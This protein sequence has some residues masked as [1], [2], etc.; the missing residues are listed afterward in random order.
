MKPAAFDYHAPESVD[1]ALELL[2]DEAVESRVLAGGQSL[3]P[4]MNFRLAVPEALV[5]LRRIEELRYLRI[6][7]DG[8]L[9]VGAR[10]TQAELLRDPAVTTGW[11]LLHDGVTHI[12]HPQVRS[13]GTVCGSLAH[14]DP[15]G[16]LPALA[17]A[18]G[19]TITVAGPAGRRQIAAEDFFV[20]FYEVALEPGELV[21]EARFPA[22]PAGSGWS[23]REIARRH[24]DFALVGVACLVTP[25]QTRLVVFGAAERPLLL[26]DPS[27][28]AAAVR[29]LDDLH[30]SAEYRRQVAVLLAGEALAEAR[31]RADG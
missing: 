24:G 21:V 1:E 26:A 20:S 22:P 14:H 18:L 9:E 29:P 19:A 10:T 23:F 4:M 17:L 16:E 15:H 11:P 3:V 12:G 7:A 6:G 25:A 30:A 5:D 8:A 2:A 31:E 28:V 13:R 27:E